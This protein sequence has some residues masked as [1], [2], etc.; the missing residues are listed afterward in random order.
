MGWGFHF[1]PDLLAAVGLCAK[2]ERVVAGLEAA[3]AF[4]TCGGDLDIS[5]VE[6]FGKTASGCVIPLFLNYAP[7]KILSV[8]ELITYFSLSADLPLLRQIK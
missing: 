5:A 3:P 4:V 6:T 1:T 7:R 2:S 8:D